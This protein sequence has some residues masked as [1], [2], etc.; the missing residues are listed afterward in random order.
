MKKIVVAV[1]LAIS[2][3]APVLAQDALLG[4]YSGS[5]RQQ[6]GSQ[7]EK[8]AGITLEILSVEGGAVKGKAARSRLGSLDNCGGEY[9]LEGKVNG[10]ELF[11]KSTSSSVGSGD[12]SMVL[13]L[14]VEGSKLAGT[15]NKGN[16]Q[17]SK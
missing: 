10:N 5:Y 17:F 2:I 4:K 9:S 6:V 11:L 15:L 13:R 12:C 16:V 1:G 8:T 14:T 3:S 7:G